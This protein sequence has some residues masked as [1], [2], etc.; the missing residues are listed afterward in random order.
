MRTALEEMIFEMML[1]NSIDTDID[2]WQE[3]H[4]K[5]EQIDLFENSDVL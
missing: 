5:P 2:V 3:D 4:K 1:F